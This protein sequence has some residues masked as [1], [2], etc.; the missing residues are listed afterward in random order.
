MKERITNI[1]RAVG[2]PD[3]Q[4]LYGKPF[5]KNE[6]QK[7]AL[8][9]LE[10]NALTHISELKK[11]SLPKAKTIVEF[12]GDKLIYRNA[13]EMKNRITP[14]NF[15]RTAML[16]DPNNQEYSFRER[17]VKFVEVFFDIPPLP[18]K[19]EKQLK[20]KD[21]SNNNSKTPLSTQEFSDTLRTKYCNDMHFT[22]LQEQPYEP[23]C[24]LSKF[25]SKFSIQE[26]QLNQAIIDFD[27]DRRIRNLSFYKIG[28]EDV[29]FE[30]NQLQRVLNNEHLTLIVDNPHT[31]K[32]K[33]ARWF[34]NTWA[35]ENLQNSPAPVY[36][37]IDASYSSKNK[38]WVEEKIHDDYIKDQN[39]DDIREI[40]MLLTYSL[41]FRLIVN[42]MDLLSSQQ[43]SEL[44]N[45]LKRLNQSNCILLTRTG[46]MLTQNYHFAN[47]I[48]LFP[49]D[50]TS[51][52][53]HINQ[54]YIEGFIY[55]RIQTNFKYQ[56][57]YRNYDTD[58]Y[59][60]KFNFFTHFAYHMHINQMNEFHGK[61]G[62][63]FDATTTLLSRR[64]LGAKV[65]ISKTNEWKFH[66]HSNSVKAYLAAR[67]AGDR[68][69][70]DQFLA[71][72][73]H[74]YFLEF[75]KMILGYKD[76]KNNVDFFTSI[77][78]KL[79]YWHEQKVETHQYLIFALMSQIRLDNY[80]YHY[81]D[82]DF[83]SYIHELIDSYA[84]STG[85]PNWQLHLLN[86]I[87]CLHERLILVDDTHLLKLL[88]RCVNK[89]LLNCYKSALDEPSSIGIA[90][91]NS[92][93]HLIKYRY[94]HHNLF[95]LQGF[96]KNL[97][98]LIEN[99]KQSNQLEP[100]GEYHS[101]EIFNTNFWS[102]LSC[103]KKLDYEQIRDFQYSI[104]NSS[105]HLTRF[106]YTNNWVE[107]ISN[108]FDQFQFLLKRCHQITELLKTR[109]SNPENNIR[110]LN[111]LITLCHK[112][113]IH[114]SNGTK[115]QKQ[116]FKQQLVKFHQSIK[117]FKGE[118][119]IHGGYQKEIY[120]AFL[121]SNIECVNT[122]IFFLEEVGELCVKQFSNDKIEELFTRVAHN[123][124]LFKKAFYFVV[125]S[126]QIFSHHL[127]AYSL[128]LLD[129]IKRTLQ[130]RRIGEENKDEIE[131]YLGWLE[132]IAKSDTT[133]WSTL[134]SI[135]RTT[136]Q[137]DPLFRE[138]I[139]SAVILHSNFHS[140]KVWNVVVRLAANY[141]VRTIVEKILAKPD[142]Y[143]DSANVLE[144]IDV[145]SAY[146]KHNPNPEKRNNSLLIQ[147]STNL[148]SAI[149]TF[150]LKNKLSN[151]L[152]MNLEFIHQ[153]KSSCDSLYYTL[154]QFYFYI[155]FS[156]E[157]HLPQLMRLFEKL[158]DKTIFKQEIVKRFTTSEINSAE[159][160]LSE[161][162]F[163]E[164]HN[165]SRERKEREKAFDPNIFEFETHRNDK[166]IKHAVLVK[167][168]SSI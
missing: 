83:E 62:D 38:Y 99:I 156:K 97:Q 112:M 60:Q 158:P 111:E 10:E 134:E 48:H 130:L 125:V 154:N 57:S 25:N 168:N 151:E 146:L 102:L 4:N 75:Q 87:T 29:N 135:W 74:P 46:S 136:L 123:E 103:L 153:I 127:K 42:G 41:K 114:C 9:F 160:W 164:L 104:R 53:E 2:N 30:R 52:K 71:L 40:S 8:T 120:R 85:N 142:Y 5:S 76:F 143:K 19:I 63:K 109:S 138:E 121:L 51:E 155:L 95:F 20:H 1:K 68:I 113:A 81:N 13:K 72:S 159:S 26:N 115:Y 90:R 73:H 144:L 31:G 152:R 67:Y 66:F 17:L 118:E 86:A 96:L 24:K 106:H 163:R 100:I 34:C 33:L 61:N 50:S 107:A 49:A 11:C 56:A 148:L 124:Q 80:K 78:P 89:Q 21:V 133:H 22:H 47:K 131:R 27:T 93:L 117:N 147:A 58:I 59:D 128:S 129:K 14:D 161:D 132:T 122:A 149:K 157:E 137:E 140:L 54:E 7:A 28:G 37:N 82:F 116:E 12:F 119:A 88:I 165:L 108:Y 162:L 43:L 77:F 145:W 166:Q 64:Q 91:I 45:K 16:M 105:P 150:N 92:L 98:K 18:H 3:N 15:A 94:F 139:L 36:L 23:V 79:K 35:H 70:P 101:N 39:V 32:E 141:R 167:T 110:R 6:I 65:S 69:Q 126:K 44:F 84:S 55:E